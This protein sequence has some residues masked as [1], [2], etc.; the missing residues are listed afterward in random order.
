MTYSGP[1]LDRKGLECESALSS[2]LPTEEEE[3]GVKEEQKI[4]HNILKEMNR[5]W[6]KI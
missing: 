6:F 1:V 5:A 4:R 3:E 2:L